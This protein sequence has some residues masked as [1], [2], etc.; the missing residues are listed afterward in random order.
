MREDQ[1]DPDVIKAALREAV[2]N[3][4]P[5]WKYIQAILRNWRSEGINSLAQVE[6]KTTRTRASQPTQCNGFRRF[7][8]GHGFVEGLGGDVLKDETGR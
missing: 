1:T 6:A 7:L 4:K 2:F 3:G 8:E 5:H